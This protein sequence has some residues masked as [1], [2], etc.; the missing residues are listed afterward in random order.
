MRQGKGQ[1]LRHLGSRR[2]CLRQLPGQSGLGLVLKFSNK[3]DLLL[4][5]VITA[6]SDLLEADGV[7]KRASDGKH[8][9][10]S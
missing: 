4:N 2:I 10:L 5:G 9:G 3:N 6:H 7:P 8:F 1:G